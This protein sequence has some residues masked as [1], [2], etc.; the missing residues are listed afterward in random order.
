LSD[1][2]VWERAGTD[3]WVDWW[4]RVRVLVRVDRLDVGRWVDRGGSGVRR[5]VDRSGDDDWRRVDRG[6][7]RWW[8]DWW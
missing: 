2:A 3:R 6:D 4:A 7:I 1:L 5:W 8:V